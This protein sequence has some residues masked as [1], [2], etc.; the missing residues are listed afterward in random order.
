MVTDFELSP[1]PLRI[2]TLYA[3]A[4]R[5]VGWANGGKGTGREHTCT[6]TDTVSRRLIPAFRPLWDIR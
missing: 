3:F 2:V 5:G 1:S 6:A 4:A